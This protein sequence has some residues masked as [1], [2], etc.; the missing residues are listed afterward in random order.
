MR[1]LL[2]ILLVSVCGLGVTLAQTA[3]DQLSYVNIQIAGDTLSN[4]KHDPAKYIYTAAVGAFYAF[5]GT[6][7]VDFP[8]VIQGPSSTWIYNQ[9]TPPVF[10]QGTA[11]GT[12]MLD[13]F[14][15]RAGG[16]ITIKNIMLSAANSNNYA[17]NEFIN[18]AAGDTII[19]DNCVLCEHDNAIKVTAAAKKVSIT[20]CLFING[21]RY[22][23]NTSGGMPIR[24]DGA[25]PDILL[26]NNTSVNMTREL[27]NGGDFFK[28]NLKELH[29][30]Y[31]NMQTNAHEIHW[32]NALQAN[33]IFYNWS[34]RGRKPVTNG[35]ESQFWTWETFANVKSRLDSLSLYHGRNL[36]Y[37]DPKILA[38]FN[39]TD[40]V[41]QCSVFNLEVDS[42][43]RA[44]NNFKIGKNYNQLNPRF[45]SPP[46]NVDSMI[47]WNKGWWSTPQPTTAPL[48]NIQRVITFNASLD[49]VLHWPP[50]FNLTYTNDTLMKA[51]TDGLPLGD[52]NWFP[53]K[54]TI[55]LAN[56]ATYIAALQDSVAH[57][58]YV[59]VP[60]DSASFWVTNFTTGVDSKG[61]GIVKQFSL[62]NSY[63]NPFNPSTTIEFGLPEQSKVTLSVF[64]ILGQKVLE[65][66][67]DYA[68]GNQSYNFD[69][70]KLSSGVY[71]YSMNATGVSGKNFVQ[72]KK[73]ILLK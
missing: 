40:S 59:Y 46:N 31:V 56:R 42:T 62:G 43:I 58:T 69:A 37:L 72:S 13:L 60:G 50:Q 32:Y 73:M 17:M 38:Y 12:T 23:F 26:E 36:F 53:A 2:S 28:S 64:N 44:D 19:V 48:W 25:C 52:L 5:N 29:Y 63:P 70:S 47:A 35:Y 30:T 6:L 54:K 8:L 20:N 27:G 21:I 24:I 65:L 14:N 4:G 18:N 9:A 15:L 61:S 41:T 34:W 7:F 11:T 16:S 39:S 10:L 49:P 3:L 66:R 22:R 68:A 1:K 67:T 51:G 57:A 45:I 33:N 71:I 55:Y